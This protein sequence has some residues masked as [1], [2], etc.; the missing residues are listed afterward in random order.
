MFFIKRGVNKALY[1]ILPNHSSSRWHTRQWRRTRN[2][3]H[4]TLT[5]RW[6]LRV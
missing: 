4:L 3:F 6:R 1:S 5:S 2:R